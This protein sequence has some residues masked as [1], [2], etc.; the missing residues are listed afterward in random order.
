[1]A[2]PQGHTVTVRE[3]AVDAAGLYAP[4]GRAAYP[5]SVL[6]C[7]IPAREAGVAG[8]P[9]PRRPGPTAR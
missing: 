1:M 2:L 6:M 7:A 5:S 3:V 9:L 8:S 4:G